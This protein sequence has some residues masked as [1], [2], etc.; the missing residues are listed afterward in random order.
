MVALL[1]GVEFSIEDRG[2]PDVMTYK[3]ASFKPNGHPAEKPVELL[4]RL[5][6]ESVRGPSLVVDPFAGSGST[7]VAAKALGHK[8]IAIEADER[9]C[10]VAA[11]RCSQETLGLPFAS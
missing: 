4:S 5:I 8:A 2:I 3:W 11:T 10:E 9:W 1:P 7:L 6:A